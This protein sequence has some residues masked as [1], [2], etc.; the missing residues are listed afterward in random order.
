V[1]TWSCNNQTNTK[2]GDPFISN[3]KYVGID[4]HLATIVVVVLN[5]ISELS[6]SD[7]RLLSGESAF[8]QGHIDVLPP[9]NAA[10]YNVGFLR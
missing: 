7:N 8:A 4:V 10:R 2:R 9:P 5:R 1:L 6:K 3:D